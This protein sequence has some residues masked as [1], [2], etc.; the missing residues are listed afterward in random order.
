MGL[1]PNKIEWRSRANPKPIDLRE[2][3][4]NQFQKGDEVY[5]NGARGSIGPLKVDQV[6]GNG[7]YK[8][9][10]KDG[11]KDKKVYDEGDLSRMPRTI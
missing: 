9:L 5:Y 8:L 1:G 4:D 10:K 6:L 7:K 3:F 2:Q 11:D